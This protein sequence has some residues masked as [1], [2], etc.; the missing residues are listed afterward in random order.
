MSDT[1]KV[2]KYWGT[3][4]A[5]AISPEEAIRAVIGR[6]DDGK[7]EQHRIDWALQRADAFKNLT[8]P[9]LPYRVNITVEV[10]VIDEGEGRGE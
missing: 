9:L 1:E 10:E 8:P 3:R 6:Q 7:D 4:Y 2:A 5:V